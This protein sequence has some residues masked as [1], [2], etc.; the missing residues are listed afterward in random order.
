MQL[1][2]FICILQIDSINN[3]CLTLLKE[4]EKKK[5]VAY[6]VY[7]WDRAQEGPHM[8]HN[9]HQKRSGTCNNIQSAY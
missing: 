2:F 6:K 7:R 1:L 4:K 9:H 3:M 8:R 5:I